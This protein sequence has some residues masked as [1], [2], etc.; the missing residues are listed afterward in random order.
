KSCNSPPACPPTR[1]EGPAWARSVMTA[2]GSRGMPIFTSWTARSCPGPRPVSIRS[3][4]SPPWRNAVWTASSP[5]TS[6]A[7]NEGGDMKLKG[8]KIGILLEGD[9]YEHEI[10]YYHFRFPEEGAELHFLTRLWGQ[11]SLTFKGHEYHAP[12]ECQESFEGM[13]DETLRSYA[14]LIVPSGMVAD[15][16]RYTDDVNKLPPATARKTS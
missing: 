14:A 10:W 2:A 13:S 3:S 4:P 11:S 8:K 6:A 9:F 12:F 15:R 7:A 16:L 5:R 1:S